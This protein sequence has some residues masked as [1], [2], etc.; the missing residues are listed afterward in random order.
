[1]SFRLGVTLISS[2]INGVEMKVNNSLSHSM[3]LNMDE[4]QDKEYN[5]IYSSY[6]LHK[7]PLT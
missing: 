5:Q 4:Q 2:E 7:Q 3:C 6:R 1:M